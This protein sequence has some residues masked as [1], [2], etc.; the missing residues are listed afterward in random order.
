M[1]VTSTKKKKI[2]S[3]PFEA[4]LEL[5]KKRKKK[6]RSV[7]NCCCCSVKALTGNSA[8]LANTQLV[9]KG[10][11]GGHAVVLGHKYS[12]RFSQERSAIMVDSA[13]LASWGV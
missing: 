12:S 2:E 10:P 3:T 11:R 6:K 4:C 9:N 8:G 7:K 1:D 13:I 5:F